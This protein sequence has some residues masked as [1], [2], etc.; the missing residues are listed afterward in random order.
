VWSCA[1][2]CPL[3]DPVTT[4]IMTSR[5]RCVRRFVPQPQ[6]GRLSTLLSHHAISINRLLNRFEELLIRPGFLHST[7]P[8]FMASTDSGT[9]RRAAVNTISIARAYP[10]E[11]PLEVEAQGLARIRLGS[12]VPRVT[13]HV[14]SPRA[15]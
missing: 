6:L 13:R 1:A 11:F 10:C 8:A 14:R 12:G 3:S 7:A 4:S 9:P 2:I 15:G 5:S